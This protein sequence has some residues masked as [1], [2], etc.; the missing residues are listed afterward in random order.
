MPVSPDLVITLTVLATAGVLFLSDR[1]RPDV[2]ALLALLALGISG[3]LTPQETFSGFSRGAVITII[4]IFIMAEG[5]RRCGATEQA[6]AALLRLAGNTEGRMVAAVMAA[7][8]TLSLVMNNIAAAA[9]LLPAV[10]SAA[11]RTSVR[12]S[13]LLIPLSFAT[14]LGGMATLLTTTNIVASGLLRDQSLEGFGLLAFAPVGL[15]IVVTGI[16]YMVAIGRRQLPIVSPAEQVAAEARER[17]DLLQLYGVDRSLFRAVVPEGS[18]MAGRPLS[19]STLREEYALEVVAVRHEGHTLFAPSADTIVIPG[20]ELLLAGD[21]NDFRRRDVEPHLHIF[22]GEVWSEE[23]LRSRDVVVAEAVVAPR[24]ALTGLSLR[25][26][27]FRT[28]YGMNVLAIWR[29]GRSILVGPSD[30][31]LQ[32]GDGLLLQGPRDRLRVLRSETDVILH[33]D[34]GAEP[35]VSSPRARRVAWGILAT[36]LLAGV[37]APEAI[38]GTML[39]GG[40]VMV[41]AGLLSMDQAYDAIDW[42][43][44][45]LVAAILP[46]GIAMSN[47]GAADLIAR[48]LLASA[49][50]YGPTA[51]LVAFVVVTVLLAQVMHGAAVVAIVTPVAIQAARQVG[52]DPRSLVMAVALATSVA[53]VTPLGHPAN[54]LVMGA[55][56]YRFRDFAKVGLPLTVI[57]VLLIVLLVPIVW[58]LA[59]P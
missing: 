20:D 10:T 22:E 53:F 42:K 52:I 41:L 46:L 59:G 34:W 4:G 36:S 18:A 12:P 49:G 24:S 45:F 28:K 9:V 57:V 43:T 38:G 58:P 27:H 17:I 44:V 33:G 51:L 40:M 1:L 21:V 48:A 26:A 7:G 25:Q 47:S 39:A 5:L 2:V 55:A 6:S 50:P 32:Y 14:I 31:R 56:G 15:P 54:L 35:V 23:R 13:R 37:L 30:V 11:R 16:V 8:A 3:V 19:E 29:A